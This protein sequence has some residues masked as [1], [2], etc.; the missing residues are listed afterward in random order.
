VAALSRLPNA[1]IQNAAVRGG[2][3]LLDWLQSQLG[4]SLIATHARFMLE[5]AKEHE[6]FAA[7]HWIMDMAREA[8]S[9]GEVVQS[10]VLD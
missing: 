9:S 2:S 1:V 3:E 7:V 10:G 5:N 8:G 6:N 4:R